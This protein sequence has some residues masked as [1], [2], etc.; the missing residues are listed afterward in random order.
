MATLVAPPLPAS[1]AASSY[2]TVTN[3]SGRA[4]NLEKLRASEQF[5]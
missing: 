3:Q 4:P 2:R 5:P 1:L